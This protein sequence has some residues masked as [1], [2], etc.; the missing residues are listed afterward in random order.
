MKIE[1]IAKIL[2]GQD[3]AIYGTELFRFNEFGECAVYDISN[4][5]CNETEE[6]LP[7]S[8]FRLD[9]ADKIV[10]HSNSVCFGCEFYDED[11]PYPLLYSNI[12]NNYAKSE[13]KMLGVCLVY[14]IRRSGNEFKSTLVQSIEVGFCD[15]ANLWKANLVNHG[16]RPYGNFAVDT[17]NRALWAFVMRNEALG[18]RFFRFDLPSVYDGEFDSVLNI[19]KF[20]MRKEDIRETFDCEYH[21]YIQGATLHKGKIYSTEG[22]QG[23]DINRPAIRA[24]DLASHNEKYF[25][26]TKLGFWDEP[27]CISF[28]GDECLYSDASGNVFKVEF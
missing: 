27:E 19:K 28:Y 7:L 1:K 21:R 16:V 13:N 3:G 18:T 6:L 14:R 17:E 5:N 8:R 4:L 23:D 22:F 24:I 2:G 11:D 12:Y 20:V 26:I 10:P 9:C 15:D 25:D